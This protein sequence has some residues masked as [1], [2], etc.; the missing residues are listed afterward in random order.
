MR[1]IA[2]DTETTGLNPKTGDRIVE[3]GCVEMIDCL[4]TGKIYHVYLNPERDMPMEAERIHGLSADFLKDK[5][6]FRNVASDFLDFIGD[7]KLVIHN[8][9]FDMKFINHELKML[10]IPEISMEQTIDT[11]MIVRKKYPGQAASLDSLC[12]RFNIDLSVRSKHGALLDA[13]LLADIYLELNGGRQSSMMLDVIE[14]KEEKNIKFDKIEINRVDIKAR[15]FP[16]DDDEI[17]LHS[18]LVEKIKEPLWSKF[19]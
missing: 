16:A 8:A 12:R 17:E 4:R 11:L 2:L 19:I 6:L 15:S 14:K 10:S 13:E 5:S 7:S 1:E 3:I 18:I 9:A